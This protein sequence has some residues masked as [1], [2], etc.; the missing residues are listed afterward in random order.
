MRRTRYRGPSSADLIR[1]TRVR[2]LLCQYGAYERQVSTKSSSSLE[3]SRSVAASRSLKQASSSAL[4]LSSSSS[5]VG[6]SSRAV[7]EDA[8]DLKLALRQAQASARDLGANGMDK[9]LALAAAQYVAL[10]LANGDLNTVDAQRVKEDF[11]HQLEQDWG[12]AGPE[13]FGL[14]RVRI[15]IKRRDDLEAIRK[16]AELDKREL[17]RQ[18]LEENAR[19]V[20]R[21]ESSRKLQSSAVSSQVKST[22]VSSSTTKVVQTRVVKTVK[23]TVQTVRAA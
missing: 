21:V 13:N 10:S 2:K 12:F 15:T 7:R 9:G 8:G 5:A 11:L 4:Q 18:R 22:K 23:R 3:A 16:K 1:Q 14:G 17:E 20:Q 6:R 19:A